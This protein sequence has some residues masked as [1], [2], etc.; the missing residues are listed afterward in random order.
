M[1]ES[2]YF[3]VLNVPSRG[4]IQGVGPADQFTSVHRL[5]TSKMPM[6]IRTERLEPQ[7]PT[8]ETSGLITFFDSRKNENPK[9]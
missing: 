3:A 7:D 8:D 4:H 2:G 9:G 6:N 5:S 1:L